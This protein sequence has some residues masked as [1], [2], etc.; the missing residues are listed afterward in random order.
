[1][2][3]IDRA[4]LAALVAGVWLLALAQMEK[5]AY[6]FHIEASDVDGLE[7]FITDVVN[8]SCTISGEVYIYDKETGY[9]SLQSGSIDC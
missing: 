6:A 8:G 1:M 4:L 5:P 3:R 7:D 9:G 2:S